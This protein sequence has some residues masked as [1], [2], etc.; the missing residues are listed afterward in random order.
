LLAGRKIG[1]KIAYV[2]FV[3]SLAAYNFI[4]VP[5]VS[6]P[7]ESPYLKWGV[8]FGINAIVVPVSIWSVVRQKRLISRLNAV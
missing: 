4:Y 2:G 1:F 5:F 8:A 7:V 6:V 3:L